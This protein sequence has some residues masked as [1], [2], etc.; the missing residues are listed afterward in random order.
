M[1]DLGRSLLDIGFAHHFTHRCF[2]DRLNSRNAL[3]GG[4]C[5]LKRNAAASSITQ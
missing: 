4:I 5:T 3:I 2:G 1:F